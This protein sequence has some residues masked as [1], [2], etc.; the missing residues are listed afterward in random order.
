[1]KPVSASRM[2]SNTSWRW[3]IKAVAGFGGCDLRCFAVIH[4]MATR[5][6]WMKL[7]LRISVRTHPGLS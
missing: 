1:M 7:N 6:E 3:G 4:S 2:R 5:T